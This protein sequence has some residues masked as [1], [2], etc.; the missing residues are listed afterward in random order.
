MFAHCC[1][2]CCCCSC[3]FHLELFSSN[4]FYLCLCLC[5]PLCHPLHHRSPSPFPSPSLFPSPSPSSCLL[6]RVRRGAFLTK[7]ESSEY[8]GFR[9]SNLDT[10]ADSARR[11]FLREGVVQGRSRS[12]S[13]AKLRMNRNFAKS[14]F[15][16][17][18]HKASEAS[19]QHHEPATLYTILD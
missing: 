12:G 16:L 10:V 18:C 7:N 3:C 14:F 19:Q 4:L 6:R 8:G 9:R 17:F 13:C 5:H 15:A 1:C 2:C 11:I